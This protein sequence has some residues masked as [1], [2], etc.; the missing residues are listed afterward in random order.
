VPFVGAHT[1]DG[2]GQE[3][4]PLARCVAPSRL[5]A[6]ESP[7]MARHDSERHLRC[8]ICSRLD[9]GQ[10]V[11]EYV[12]PTDDPDDPVQQLVQVPSR[13]MTYTRQCP[14]CGTCYLLHH[15]CYEFLIGFGGSY[16]EY[17]LE[18]LPDEESADAVD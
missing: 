18:R 16:D 3:R 9:D 7:P 13:R 2:R 10:T 12:Q 5:D 8:S 17:R 4:V 1:C 11:T 14:E 15:L 6:L